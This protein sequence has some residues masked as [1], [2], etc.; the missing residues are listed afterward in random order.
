M[1][2]EAA[3]S[4]QT[5][6]HSRVKCLDATV[7]NLWET[8]EAVDLNHRK[9]GGLQGLVCTAGTDQLTAEGMKTLSEGNEVGLV[10]DG[11]KGALDRNC[12]LESMNDSRAARSKRKRASE[13]YQ[14]QC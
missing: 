10:R 14:L 13:Q 9:T 12:G 2:L 5:A 1:L 6:M 8:S 3:N 4:Q 11:Q 7:E